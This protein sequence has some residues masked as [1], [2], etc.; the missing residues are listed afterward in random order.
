[1]IEKLKKES[2][3]PHMNDK[4]EIHTKSAAVV[5]VELVEVTDHSSG[6]LESFSVVFR[7]AHDKVFEQDTHKV[8]HP[9]I[10][11]FDLFLGPIVT[12][13]TDGIYYQAVFSRLIEK[14]NG[15]SKKQKK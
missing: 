2:F 15:R 1:M 5:E 8:K 10:G 4:F 3:T 13:K 11:E 14:K 6:K 9:K 12:P 7:G